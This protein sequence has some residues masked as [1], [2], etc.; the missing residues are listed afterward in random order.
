MNYNDEGLLSPLG[1]QEMAKAY[2]EEINK[3]EFVFVRLDS[4][5]EQAFLH[6]CLQLLHLLKHTLFT[7]GGFLGT[8]A[9]YNLNEKHI[10]KIEKL[11][12]ISFEYKQKHIARD[13]TKCFLNMLSLESLLINNLL[14]LAQQSQFGKEILDIIKERTSLTSSLFKINGVISSYF[15]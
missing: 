7:L 6:E 11:F 13:K 8:G 10:L 4:S 1:Y 5:K 2:A 3:K 15:L 12:Q 9:L 14:N